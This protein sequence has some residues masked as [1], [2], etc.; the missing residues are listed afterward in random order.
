LRLR[1]ARSYPGSVRGLSANRTASSRVRWDDGLPCNVIGSPSLNGNG[2]V[3]AAT[4]GSYSSSTGTY[5]R[6]AAGAGR[7][8]GPACDDTDGAPHVYVLDGRHPVADAAGRPDAPVL[9]CHQLPSGAFAQPTF[10]DGY[11]FVASGA[12]G[13]ASV[14]PRLTTF[15]A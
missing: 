1:A 8:Y 12:T 10:A 9:W 5:Q 6:C 15:T 4:Y 14:A 3:A 13:P 11:L 2:L 7:H